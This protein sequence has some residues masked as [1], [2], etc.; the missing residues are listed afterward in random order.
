MFGPPLAFIL[1][2]VALFK[3][4]SKKYPIAGLFISGLTILLWVLP[5]LCM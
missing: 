4:E 2:I 3:G 1:C 5:M